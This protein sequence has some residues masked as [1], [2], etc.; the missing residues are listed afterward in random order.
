M[1]TGLPGLR[2]PLPSGRL[3]GSCSLH[4]H[5]ACCDTLVKSART[6]AHSTPVYG[7]GNR[8]PCPLSG[9]ARAGTVAGGR[10]PG[11]SRRPCCPRRRRACTY[12]GLPSFLEQSFPPQRPLHGGHGRRAAQRTDARAGGA[13]GTAPVRHLEELRSGSLPLTGAHGSPTVESIMLPQAAGEGRDGEGPEA[14]EHEGR[15]PWAH[16]KLRTVAS[17]TFLSAAKPQLGDQAS[18]DLGPWQHPHPTLTL[19]WLLPGCSLG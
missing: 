5:C 17:L 9:T 12:R 6:Q 3:P 10:R 13:E 19:Q 15:W 11:P 2:L 16:P 8:V 1:S 7:C 14:A 4:A 18:C